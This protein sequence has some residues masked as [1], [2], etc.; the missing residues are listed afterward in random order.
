MNI[1]ELLKNLE[2]IHTIKSIMSEL[3]ISKSKAIYYVHLLRKHGYVKTKRMSNKTRVYNISFSN[4]L[5]GT[6]YEDIINQYSPIKIST[7]KKYLLYGKA[8]TLEETLIYAIKTK[9]LRTILASIG[10]FRKINH[11]SELYK[12]AKK[13]HIERQVGALYDLARL[14]IRTKRMSKIFIRNDL[15]KK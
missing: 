10:L 1:K 11:W 6:T 13:N 12:L 4:K 15:P 9:N 5:K 2:G 14:F 3:N 7:F 8:P